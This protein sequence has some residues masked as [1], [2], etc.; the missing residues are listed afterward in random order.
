MDFDAYLPEMAVG[1][2]PR[3]LKLYVSFSV[4]S[5]NIFKTFVRNVKYQKFELSSGSYFL[6]GVVLIN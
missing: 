2:S 5:K 6:H 1:G 4:T 3:S